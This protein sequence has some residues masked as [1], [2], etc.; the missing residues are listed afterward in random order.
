MSR[1]AGFRKRKHRL[2]GSEMRRCDPNSSYVPMRI[3]IT[4]HDK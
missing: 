2:E 1:H 3:R 4:S